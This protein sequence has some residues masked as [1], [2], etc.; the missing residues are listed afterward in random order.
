ML[1]ILWLWLVSA[2]VEKCL[3]CGINWDFVRRA[4][5]KTS[6]LLGKCWQ[7]DGCTSSK[8]ALCI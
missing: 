7:Y 1:E 6:A 3:F 4:G 8:G 2:C 5:G